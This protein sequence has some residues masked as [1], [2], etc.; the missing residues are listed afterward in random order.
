MLMVYHC[1][2]SNAE[3]EI[4]DHDVISYL[5]NICPTN[6]KRKVVVLPNCLPEQE[7]RLKVGVI[8]KE[9]VVKIFDAIGACSC[10]VYFIGSR[11]M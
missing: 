4:L 9:T 10:D 8:R 6:L 7:G 3:L 11:R 5:Q 2:K 1:C